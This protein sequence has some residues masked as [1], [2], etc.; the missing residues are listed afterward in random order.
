MSKDQRTMNPPAIDDRRHRLG[1]I[2]G[3]FVVAMIAIMYLGSSY[4]AIHPAGH[5]ISGLIW[6]IVAFII[7]KTSIRRQRV[8]QWFYYVWAAL[9]VIG[10]ILWLATTIVLIPR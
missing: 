10:M 4:Y 2:L 9:V 5:P 6:S 8:P 1:I 7:L 3:I